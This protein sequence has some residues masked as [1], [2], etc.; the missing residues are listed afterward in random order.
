MTRRKS[1]PRYEE[2]KELCSHNWSML[3]HPPFW[4]KQL[5]DEYLG[6]QSLR[7]Q[8]VPYSPKSVRRLQERSGLYT[9]IISPFF[10]KH[11]DHSYF[12]YVGKTNNIKRRFEEYLH[13]ATDEEGRHLL[14]SLLIPY[15]RF[16]TF[17]YTYVDE[18]ELSVYEKAFITCVQP[19][20]NIRDR[21]VIAHLLQGH[22]AW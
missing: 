20:C 10:G 6:L 5:R 19:P 15:K 2:I 18:P 13:E 22:P 4:T 21:G 1:N 12:V 3:L 8:K 11:S 17:K 16:I 14:V 7:W 9:F